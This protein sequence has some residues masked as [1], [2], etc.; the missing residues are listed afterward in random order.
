VLIGGDGRDELFGSLQGD[1]LIG[2]TT[3]FDDNADALL[4]ILNEWT[5]TRAYAERVANLR[6]T[7]SGPA[8]DERLND[9]IFL[10]AGTTVLDDADEDRLHGLL[11]F[12]WFFAT[13]SGLKKDKVTGRR[14]GELLDVLPPQ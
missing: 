11:G 2:G 4:L 3:A 6:G 9:N 10:Q 12:D 8:F 5:S 14:S 1:L 13:V 7:G